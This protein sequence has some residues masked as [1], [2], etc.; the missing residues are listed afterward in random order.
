MSWQCARGGPS[1]YYCPCS[2]KGYCIYCVKSPTLAGGL[3]WIAPERLAG[4]PRAS[5]GPAHVLDISSLL[6]MKLAGAWSLPNCMNVKEQ[7]LVPSTPDISELASSVGKA[8]ALS[9]PLFQQ[10]Y[11]VVPL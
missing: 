11:R 2:L 6:I 4:V 9:C 1:V 5:K 8:R 3:W 7:S 10:P